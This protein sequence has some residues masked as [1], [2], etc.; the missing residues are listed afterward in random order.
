VQALEIVAKIQ[1]SRADS[2]RYITPTPTSSSSSATTTTEHTPIPP[3]GCKAFIKPHV[4]RLPLATF[5]SRLRG[6]GTAAAEGADEAL[7]LQS[8]D[9]NVY[10]ASPRP[11]GG[12]ELAGMRGWVERDVGWMRE[13]S[14]EWG[15]VRGVRRAG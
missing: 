15:A 13:A 4:A 1:R 8:Q 6:G 11:E 3:E 7:Y 9:G 10:R 12:E 5:L 14:G 2:V